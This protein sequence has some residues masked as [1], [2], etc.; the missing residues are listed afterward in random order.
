MVVLCYH[1]ATACI[2]K[3]LTMLLSQHTGSCEVELQVVS[4]AS[5][6]CRS[7]ALQWLHW[8]HWVYV[9]LRLVYLPP[10]PVVTTRKLVVLRLLP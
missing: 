5:M 9:T 2:N 4:A 6:C 1:A 7:K 3:I 8:L 10:Q